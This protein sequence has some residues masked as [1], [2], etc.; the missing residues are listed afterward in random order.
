M[1]SQPIKKTATSGGCNSQEIPKASRQSPLR[2]LD[3]LRPWRLWSKTKAFQA[4]VYVEL[5]WDLRRQMIINSA[6]VTASIIKMRKI[7]REH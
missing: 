3:I 7:T 4:F 2:K 6:Q 5:K 1:Q